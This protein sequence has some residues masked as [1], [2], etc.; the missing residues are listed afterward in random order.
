MTK[1]GYRLQATGYRKGTVESLP[2]ARRSKP[3]AGILQ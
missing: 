1:D 2:A 3:V